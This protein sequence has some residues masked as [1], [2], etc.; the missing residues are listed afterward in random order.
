M[1]STTGWIAALMA[2][3][4]LAL[5]GCGGGEAKPA[6]G[7]AAAGTGAATDAGGGAGTATAAMTKYKCSKAECKQTKEAKAGE[8]APNC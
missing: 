6:G 5:T 2:S 8:P 4:G 7:G 3:A 1:Q